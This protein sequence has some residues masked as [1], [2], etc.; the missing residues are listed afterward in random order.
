MKR[1]LKDVEGPMSMLTA[2]GCYK[3]RDWQRWRRR[4]SAGFNTRERGCAINKRRNR[5]WRI[6]TKGCSN[7]GNSFTIH[8][9]IVQAKMIQHDSIEV[10][11]DGIGMGMGRKVRRGGCGE[12]FVEWWKVLDP[13]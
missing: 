13:M 2:E 1:R 12:S 5:A 3:A 10:V 4:G 6:H 9:D 7:D 8:R 11:V